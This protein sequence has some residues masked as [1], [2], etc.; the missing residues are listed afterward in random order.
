M[1]PLEVVER[2]LLRSFALRDGRQGRLF[3]ARDRMGQKPVYYTVSNGV[4]AVASELKALLRL[5]SLPRR[6]DRPC[7]L[8]WL[9]YCITRVLQV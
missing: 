4:L 2:H 1:R 9:A 8:E 3:C 7:T 5:P 6:I